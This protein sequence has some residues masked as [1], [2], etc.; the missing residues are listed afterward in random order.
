MGD[1]DVYTVHHMVWVRP[2]FSFFSFFCYLKF[3]FNLFLPVIAS[4]FDGGDVI[5]SA[6]CGG[7]QSGS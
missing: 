5:M 6:V 2:C 3:K 7:W 1:S 4:D